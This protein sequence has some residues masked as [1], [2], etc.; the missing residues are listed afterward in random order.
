MDHRRNSRVNYPMVR[1]VGFFTINPPPDQSQA[2]LDPIGPSTSSPASNNSLS[3]VMIPPPR[4]QLDSA[5]RAVNVPA[6][7]TRTTSRRHRPSVDDYSNT[8][9]SDSETLIV[10]S[11]NPADS[12]LGTSPP[13]SGLDESEVER[14]SEFSKNL[15]NWSSIGDSAK[16]PSS[17]PAKGFDSAAI[18]KV[19]NVKKVQ[20]GSSQ[21]N[22]DGDTFLQLSALLI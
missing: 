1:Q 6:S 5:S 16:L 20:E 10:G 19:Q 22:G 17:L 18:P 14:E 11:Y 9:N 21:G 13:L 7:R 8:G 2:E 4:H 3:P 12:V 15:V